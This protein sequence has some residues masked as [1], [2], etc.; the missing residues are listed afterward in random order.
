[1][2]T[3]PDQSSALDQLFC[4]ECTYNLQ[5]LTS[6]RCPECGYSLEWVRSPISRIPWVHRDTIGSLRAYWQTVWMVG[7]RNKHFCEEIAKPVDHHHANSFRWV[8]ILHAQLAVLALTLLFWL[9]HSPTLPPITAHPFLTVLLLYGTPHIACF[10]FLAAA[11]GIPGYFFTADA[12]PTELQNRAIALSYYACAALALL[13]IAAA[14]AFVGH[15]AAPFS[16]RLANSIFTIAGSVPLVLFFLYRSDLVL[17]ARRAMPHLPRRIAA[18]SIVLP[19]LW[20]ILFFLIALGLP[21]SA[22]YIYI[23]Y[24]SLP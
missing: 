8:T 21:I 15:A 22:L 9:G 13:F 4:P 23:I 24:A 6:D 10:L 5:A 3:D 17:L 12:L 2:T 14:L 18:L 20:I 19:I 16:R 11:T 1:M 7:R